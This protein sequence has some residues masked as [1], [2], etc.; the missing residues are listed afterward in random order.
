MSPILLI[1]T[2]G[3]PQALRAVDWVIEQAP[4]WKERPTVHVLTVQPSLHGDISRFVSAAQLQEFHREEGDKLLAP[5]LERLRA[6]GM[7]PQAHVRVGESADVIQSFAVELGCH[8]I[9]MGTRGHS[10]LKGM[11]LGSVATKLAHLSAVPLT[12]VR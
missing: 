8:Q 3:S 10:G 11:L 12:L 5:A 6:A 9:V 7:T 4:L 1:P 2:D